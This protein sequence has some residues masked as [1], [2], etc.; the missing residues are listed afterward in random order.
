MVDM[1]N[2]F[3]KWKIKSHKNR[4]FTPIIPSD[5]VSTN[6]IHFV[7]ETFTIDNDNS[8]N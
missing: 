4:Y 8:P 3:N 6:I 1:V 5:P 2:F 7:H